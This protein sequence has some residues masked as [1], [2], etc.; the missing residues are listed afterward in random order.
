MNNNN[1]HVKHTKS[2]LNKLAIITSVVGI[3]TLVSSPIWA[4]Y[5][6]NR[7]SLFNRLTNTR[8]CDCDV[9]TIL[10]D[11]DDFDN[12][13]AELEAA[14][15]ADESNLANENENFTI[16]APSD[17]AFEKLSVQEFEKFKDSREQILKSHVVIGE[18]TPDQV[19]QAGPVTLA[20]LGGG[21]ITLTFNE[22][23]E[24]KLNRVANAKYPA[25]FAK[26]GT[27]VEIDTVIM[28]GQ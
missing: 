19:E 1:H 20:T 2:W 9:I 3:G 16:F 13:L 28:P 4:G 25:S 14:G 22:D 26:N 21:E 12:F 11:H 7:Y 5:Y 17:E 23:N 8:D 10:R 27:I 18:L 24:A 15:L 6:P